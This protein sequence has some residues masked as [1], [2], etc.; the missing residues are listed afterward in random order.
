MSLPFIFSSSSPWASGFPVHKEN[1]VCCNGCSPL[2]GLKNFHWSLPAS[3]QEFYS[4]FE[5]L[6]N[7]YYDNIL[8]E[9]K[10]IDYNEMRGL[11]AY[12][13]LMEL[14]YYLNKL[15]H[16]SNYIDKLVPLMVKYIPARYNSVL[17]YVRGRPAEI[18]FMSEI[19]GNK[20]QE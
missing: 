4:E 11:W 19:L 7:I 16:I 10:K 18:L 14:T 3:N 12:T 13:S 20:C 2:T 1:C 17:E 9:L 15:L 6:K 8:P 5:L